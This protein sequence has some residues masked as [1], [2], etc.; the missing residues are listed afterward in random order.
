MRKILKIDIKDKVVI[1]S[2]MYEGVAKIGDPIQIAKKAEENSID[3]V[4]LSNITGSLY[5]HDNFKNIL[6]N[7]CSEVFLP[8][9]V[10]GGIKNIKDCETYFSLGADKISLNSILFDNKKLLN[11]TVNNFGSQSVTVLIQSKKI[12]NNWYAFRDMARH[13]TNVLVSDWI[14]FCEQSGAGEIILVSVDDD[15]L[16]RGLNYEM[17]NLCHN[18]NIPIILSGGFCGEKD[19]KKI[20][21]YKNFNGLTVSSYFYNDHITQ[22]I[23]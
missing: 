15:G 18:S 14:K 21:N 12:G 1:K 6:S 11:E 5:G 2:I 22:K 16:M 7:I 10:G 8:I 19:I 20:S 17:S 13:N 3:E 4:F 9:T 23:I